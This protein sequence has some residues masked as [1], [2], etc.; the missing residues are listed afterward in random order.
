VK[1]I[2]D[3][4]KLQA[5]LPIIATLGGVQRYRRLV[6]DPQKVRRWTRNG[7][8][9]P[10]VLV[11]YFSLGQAA[12]RRQAATDE[13]T[14]QGDVSV[15]RPLYGRKDRVAGLL[16]PLWALLLVELLIGKRA[17]ISRGRAILLALEPAVYVAVAQTLRSRETPLSRWSALGKPPTDHE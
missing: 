16:R 10:A 3:G 4:G 13:A 1:G 11:A 5:A 15:G 6:A 12:G 8:I 2:G 17:K 14:P 7:A 9:V